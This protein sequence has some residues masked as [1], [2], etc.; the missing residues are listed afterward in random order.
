MNLLYNINNFQD[1][2]IIY[3]Y[4]HIYYA[5]NTTDTKFYIGLRR[6]NGTWQWSDGTQLDFVNFLNGWIFRLFNSQIIPQAT[7]HII[8][9]KICKRGSSAGTPA[10]AR[11][12]NIPCV[13]LISLTIL[14]RQ[15]VDSRQVEL[16]GQ[17]LLVHVRFDLFENF[18][19]CFFLDKCPIGWL[20]SF[21]QSN[22]CYFI[23][24]GRL[25]GIT[26]IF[27]LYFSVT[28]FC[29]LIIFSKRQCNQFRGDVIEIGS[30]FENSEIRRNFRR[31]LLRLTF[32]DRRICQRLA[33]SSTNQRHLAVDKWQREKKSNKKTPQESAYRNWAPG[34][35]RPE[36][37]CTFIEGGS[38]LWFSKDC[39]ENMT[40]TCQ[41]FV[42]NKLPL[43]LHAKRKD[44]LER[45]N[46]VQ[47][48]EKFVETCRK[49]YCQL[50]SR[51]NVFEQKYGEPQRRSLKTLSINS[52]EVSMPPSQ[53]DQSPKDP[54]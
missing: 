51:E 46:H 16:R 35:P 23:D 1:M 42:W 5:W 52:R 4:S 50:N 31:K 45:E 32:R 37:S 33:R 41:I 20:P 9:Q 39:G 29:R 47:R 2:K 21:T 17:Q 44:Q 27:L 19:H 25:V 24:D 6:V 18:F 3:N 49:K 26:V 15:L 43:T 48:I 7:V 54:V 14:Q 38:G 30:G 40:P 12:L 11:P 36:N 53:E 22:E 28:K 10:T 34:E 13:P 8:W